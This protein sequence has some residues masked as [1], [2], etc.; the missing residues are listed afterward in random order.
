MKFVDVEGDLNIPLNL[1]KLPKSLSK[2]IG[3][4]P[5][6]I[7]VKEEKWN[8]IMALINSNQDDSKL[9]ICEDSIIFGKQLINNRYEPIPNF[10]YSFGFPYGENN[11]FKGLYDWILDSYVDMKIG[12]VLNFEESVENDN[13]LYENLIKEE[14]IEMDIEETD[15]NNM[16]MENIILENKPKNGID[17]LDFKIDF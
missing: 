8:E 16:I 5:T 13:D 17:Q 3:F 4:W 12:T 15:D 11:G 14:N 1:S 2:I 7:M 10:R 9:D 6:F